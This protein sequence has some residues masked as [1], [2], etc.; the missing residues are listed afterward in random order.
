MKELDR[1]AD[2]VIRRGHEYKVSNLKSLAVQFGCPRKIIKL[3]VQDIK[4]KHYDYLITS[5]NRLMEHPY[6]N[7]AEDF[8]M[9]F[10]VPRTASVTLLD[11]PKLNYTVEGIPYMTANGRRKTSKSEVTVHGRGSG[12]I[13]INGQNVLY[14]EHP[15]D[16]EQVVFPLQFTGL[17]DE[18]D[19]EAKVWD[20]GQSGQS[21][22]VRIALALALR[23]FVDKEMIENMRI[24]FFIKH[25]PDLTYSIERTY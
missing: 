16:R 2:Q 10:R 12:K 9:R 17:L 6:A 13:S 5:L 22:A 18:V 19:V 3:L 20:G 7:Q 15:Q 4:D 24:A 21:G 14:F 25:L 1:Y 8:L 23:S 11:I